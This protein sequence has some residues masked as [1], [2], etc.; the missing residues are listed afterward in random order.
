[1]YFIKSGEVSIVYNEKGFDKEFYSI[2]EKTE[3]DYFGEIELL[4]E[5]ERKFTY[6]AKRDCELLKIN[7]ENL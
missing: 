5:E 7:K 3:K 4:F 6:K 2:A 1:M